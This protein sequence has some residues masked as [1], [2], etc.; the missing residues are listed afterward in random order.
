MDSSNYYSTMLH[1]LLDVVVHEEASDIHLSVG[2][3]PLVRID[4]VLNPVDR[5]PLLTEDDV[6]GMI[7]VMLDGDAFGR[8]M[9]DLDIDFSYATG[10]GSRFRGN[11]FMAQGAHGVVL[12][13]IPSVVRSMEELGLPPILESFT[14][15]KQGLFLVTGPVGQGKSSTLAAMIERINETRNAHIMTIED[16]VEYTYTP[17]L[18]HITQREVRVDTRDFQS[19][20][21]AALRQDINVLFVGEMRGLEA[22]ATT[23]TAAETG[24]LVFSAL[25][26]NN[27]SQ[28]LDRIID[29]FP[30][31]QQDQ[32]RY[33]ISS[34]LMG[35]FS[36]RLL[37]KV[38]GGRVLAC[39]LLI[40][41]PG[42]ANLI[43]ERRTHE[44]PTAIETGRE[45]GMIDMNRSLAELVQKG[46]ITVEVAYAASFNPKGL[47]RLL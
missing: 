29:S 42:V 11:A 20:L 44:I 24:H 7:R 23:V 8:Y 22:T 4:G 3:H 34:T 46:D 12:R 45:Y 36:Q 17:K 35:I 13:Y 31:A 33:Q 1:A 14:K 2:S 19:G 10:D 9:Q 39:E 38:G 6:I 30:A 15:R 47:E 21:Y 37:P 16:P 28:T 26:T 41:N 18:S 27:A 40:N 25:H 32:I 43:R 5:H